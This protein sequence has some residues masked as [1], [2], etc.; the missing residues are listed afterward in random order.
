[1]IRV[2]LYC[3]N[4]PQAEK[5]S[6]LSHVQPIRC[7]DVQVVWRFERVTEYRSAENHAIVERRE[8]GK[9]DVHFISGHGWGRNENIRVNSSN[10]II[11]SSV[12]ALK[13]L[14]RAVRLEAFLCRFKYAAG[15]FAVVK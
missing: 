7:I 2:E 5:V 10:R 15:G 9:R 14:G 13:G 3:A 1:M 4:T 11:S 12:V 6:I 8:V